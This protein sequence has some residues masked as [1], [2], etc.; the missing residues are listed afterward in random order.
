MQTRKNCVKAYPRCQGK[1]LSLAFAW[2]WGNRETMRGTHSR[3]AMYNF[4]SDTK[5]IDQH[6]LGSNASIYK[7][8]D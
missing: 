4:K 7:K 3:H 1:A 6:S 2:G 5:E 8:Q